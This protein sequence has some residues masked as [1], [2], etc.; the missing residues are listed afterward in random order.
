MAHPLISDNSKYSTYLMKN[1]NLGCTSVARRECMMMGRALRRWL[2]VGVVVAV[3]AGC[4][5]GNRGRADPDREGV[6]GPRPSSPSRVMRWPSTPQGCDRAGDHRRE[7][8]GHRGPGGVH[9]GRAGHEGHAFPQ[10]GRGDLLRGHLLLRL[11]DQKK[12]G[13]DDKLSTW[14]PELPNADQ[15][16]LRMLANMTAGYADYVP[17]KQ[18]TGDLPRPVSGHGLRRS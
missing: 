13:L 4:T 15:V 12:V 7:G 6:P 9:D 5:G 10:R 16:T 17:T 3:A 1:G 2:A 18:L 14:L 11:V 8:G